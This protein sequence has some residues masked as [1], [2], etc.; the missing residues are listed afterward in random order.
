MALGSVSL[1][2][3]GLGLN[4]THIGECNPVSNHNILNI[5]GL[6]STETPEFSTIGEIPGRTIVRSLL[7]KMIL[8]GVLMFLTVTVASRDDR[9]S[10][11]TSRVLG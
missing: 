9:I 1:I 10:A 4:E 3:N 6:V 8:C 7:G 5:Q 2:A 11:E